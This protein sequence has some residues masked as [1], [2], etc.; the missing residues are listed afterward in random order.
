MKQQPIVMKILYLLASLSISLSCIA[1]NINGK[2][3]YQI[4]T[5]VD[6]EKWNDGQISEP[7]KT[8]ITQRMKRFLEKT[9]TLTFNERESIYKEDEKLETSVGRGRFSSIIGSFSTG[10]Q[11]KNIEN[12]QLLEEREF[13]GKQFLINDSIPRL[14]WTISKESK[15]IGQYLVIKATATKKAEETDFSLIKSRIQRRIKNQTKEKKNEA[16]KDS[17]SS[18]GMIDEIET[19]KEVLVT[20]WFTPQ[21][22]VKTGPEEYG[23][24]PGL[25]LEINIDRKTILCSKIIINPSRVNKISIPKKGKEVTR[26]VFHK[27]VKGKTEELHENWSRNRNQNRGKRGF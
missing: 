10:L 24:L 18:E 13:F 22:P 1:Q 15:M 12:N 25:I 14:N 5:T 21:I 6:L 19:S 17:I 26:D 2:A 20:A 7:T 4:K 16:I 23:G 3:Y 9:Y 27:I 11:Y 8:Q